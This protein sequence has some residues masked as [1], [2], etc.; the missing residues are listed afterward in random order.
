MPPTVPVDHHPLGCLLFLLTPQSRTKNVCVTQ[1]GPVSL[2]H[3]E[4]FKAFP[5]VLT[6]RHACLEHSV[7]L[8]VNG[9]VLETRRCEM[10]SS[11]TNDRSAAFQTC[12]IVSPSDFSSFTSS[13]KSLRELPAFLFI[14]TGEDSK[15]QHG[16]ASFRSAFDPHHCSL[17]KTLE[18]FVPCISSSPLFQLRA[19]QLQQL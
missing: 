1:P 6:A 11:I 3:A 16:N 2:S 18:I 12:S 9:L 10:P 19:F 7:L 14:L 8:K 15:Q 5:C 17:Q 4:A 13:M